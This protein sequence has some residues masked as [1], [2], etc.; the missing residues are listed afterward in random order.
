MPKNR[1]LLLR[2]QIEAKKNPRI[3]RE[4]RPEVLLSTIG[5]IHMQINNREYFGPILK[6]CIVGQN[7]RASCG[8]TKANVKLCSF[9]R[10]LITFELEPSI[11]F[12]V[13]TTFPAG[14]LGT[15][16]LPIEIQLPKMG[17]R[18]VPDF[19]IGKPLGDRIHYNEE[20]FTDFSSFS[21]K[22]HLESLQILASLTHCCR[23]TISVLC[24]FSRICDTGRFPGFASQISLQMQMTA[25]ISNGFASIP[26]KENG[27]QP[28]F[29]FP[30]ERGKFTN[31][32]E[33]TQTRLQLLLSRDLWLSPKPQFQHLS[34]SYVINFRYHSTRI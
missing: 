3:G 31:C 7:I 32:S 12:S 29:D 4:N 27:I 2:K 9:F 17:K 5:Y 19:Q 23:S 20:I 11:N 18:A 25:A 16:S 10:W 21:V 30:W 6:D 8:Q 33:I 1:G 22:D 34:G 26:S 15:A 24:S 28:W 13:L 14:K